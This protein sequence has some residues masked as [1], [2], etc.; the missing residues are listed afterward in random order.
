MGPRSSPVC[1]GMNLPDLWGSTFVIIYGQEKER[2]RER[3]NPPPPSLSFRYTQRSL[4]PCFSSFLSFNKISRSI[5]SLFP[6]HPI[7]LLLIP[8]LSHCVYICMSDSAL[9]LKTSFFSP[10]FKRRFSLNF[11]FSHSGILG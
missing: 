2:E 4:T 1:R 7:L 3:E 8:L 10:P 9:M 6:F 5:S 11:N